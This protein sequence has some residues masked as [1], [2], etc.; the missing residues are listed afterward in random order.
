[1]SE[2]VEIFF[3]YAHEDEVM[4]KNLKKHLKALHWQRLI[5]TWYDGEI[6][7]GTEWEQEIHK[8]LNR[9]QIILLLVSP[10][11]IA[12][13]YCYNK[14]MMRAMERHERKEARVIP[15]MLRPVDYS[16]TPF[17]KLQALPKD[18]LPIT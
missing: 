6:S 14:E 2:S 10:D 7:G 15:I 11:F 8:H 17:S 1:M 3:C 9:A 13:D 18:A 5:K 12:S 16:G 4:L